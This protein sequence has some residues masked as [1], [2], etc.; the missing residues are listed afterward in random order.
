VVNRYA[1]KS[2]ST[3]SVHPLTCFIEQYNSETRNLKRAQVNTYNSGALRY[4]TDGDKW[5]LEACAD[6]DLTNCEVVRP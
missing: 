6:N 2:L 4:W 1:T 3:A 5:T